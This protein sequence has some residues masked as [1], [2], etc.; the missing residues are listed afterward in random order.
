MSEAAV[1]Q[2]LPEDVRGVRDNGFVRT[3]SPLLVDCLKGR[4]A[5][6]VIF[7][8][9]VVQDVRV[10]LGYHWQVQFSPMC[11]VFAQDDL[12]GVGFVA[13]VE[14]AASALPVSNTEWWT[15]RRAALLST[16]VI[17]I[18]QSWSTCES[19]ENGVCTAFQLVDRRIDGF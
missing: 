5:G 8:D 13:Q 1:M 9:G 12:A 2:A 4:A 16:Q 11:L 7:G 19:A 14:R 6:R 15:A 10:E 17:T 18:R 3:K